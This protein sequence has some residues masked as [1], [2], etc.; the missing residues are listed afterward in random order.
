MYIQEIKSNGQPNQYTIIY[1]WLKDD[2]TDA[3]IAIEQE[4]YPAPK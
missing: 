1:H 4:K 3:E 2:A